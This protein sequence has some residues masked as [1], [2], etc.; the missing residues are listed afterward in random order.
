MNIKYEFSKKFQS[1][2]NAGDISAFFL[3][4]E[5]R[6]KYNQFVSVKLLSF[7]DSD[8]AGIEVTK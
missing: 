6:G 2:K 5:F 4:N 1:F 7:S 3:K 8:H